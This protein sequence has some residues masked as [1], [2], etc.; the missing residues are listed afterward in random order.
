LKATA[1]IPKK[2]TIGASKNGSVGG[3]S[4]VGGEPGLDNDLKP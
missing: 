2:R 4:V 1:L 3:R